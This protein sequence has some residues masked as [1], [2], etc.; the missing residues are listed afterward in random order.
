MKAM[1]AGKAG[2]ALVKLAC[3]T[4][5]VVKKLNNGRVR[6]SGQGTK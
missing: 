5:R 2:R 6:V 3:I 1:A 4:K